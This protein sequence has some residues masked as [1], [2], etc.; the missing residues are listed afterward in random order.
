M[1]DHPRKLV[2]CMVLCLFT[3]SLTL[4]VWVPEALAQQQNCTEKLAQAEQLYMEVQPEEAIAL[5]T[6]CIE[7]NEFTQEE[8]QRAYRLLALSYISNEQFD[9]ARD[10]VRDLLRFAPDYQV[11]PVQDPP[12]FVTLIEEIR[13][14]ITPPVVAEQPK[15]KGGISKWL[16]IG[17]GVVAG[18]VL[19]AVLAG[20]GGS[21]GNGNG[22][23]PPPPP[24][25]AAP[26]PL[27]GGN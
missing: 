23:G 7:T 14:P 10:A 25:I 26:P 2:Y 4:A 21:N 16:L 22:N 13:P 8:R 18:G 6:E 12:V 27:P 1:D 20:G 3:L 19:A 9:E 11:D 24:T 17:G 15:R 5:L